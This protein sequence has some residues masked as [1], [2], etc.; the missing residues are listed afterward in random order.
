[1]TDEQAR[2]VQNMHACLALHPAVLNAAASSA[3][4]GLLLG[5]DDF[6]R[7][8]AEHIAEGANDALA[9]N[10]K[11]AALES[12][13]PDRIAAAIEQC[14]A[15]IFLYR[16][17]TLSA[18]DPKGPLFL[19]PIK[20]AMQANWKKSILFKDY[21]PHFYEAFSEPRERIAGRNQR[22]I[23]LAGDASQVVFSQPGG[24][25]LVGS[26]GQDQSWTSID[27]AG[28]V[29]LVPGEIATA[30]RNLE[31]EVRFSG[32][33]LSTIPFAV[34]YG[35][36]RNFATIHIRDSQ[37]VDFH[38]DDS[39]FSADFDKYLSANP[40]NAMV[41]EFGIGTNCGVTGLYGLNAGFEERHPGLHLG[42]GGGAMG[43][44]HLDL[45]FADGRLSF[46]DRIVFDG[47]FLI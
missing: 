38:S 11:L 19:L 42:L 16:S 2:S 9:M 39:R 1:M 5:F 26:I 40:G 27:G 6:H 37:V 17:S 35:V 45:I 21:G 8:I 12:E 30:I 7:D 36:V 29:D 25:K 43:S 4:I 44:H 46:D 47:G 15:F 20:Q 3:T 33:F 23:E 28:N 24:G 32:A 31:G 22:L 13:P 18:V 14:D 10:V 41:E 34:K